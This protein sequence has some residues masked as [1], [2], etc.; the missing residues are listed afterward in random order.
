[1]NKSRIDN[2]IQD[3]QTLTLMKSLLI[4]LMLVTSVYAEQPQKVSDTQFSNSVAIDYNGEEL[5]LSL[6]GLT[7][8]KKLIFKVYLM[9][10]YIEKT[11]DNNF[12]ISD[13]DI[14][15]TVLQHEGAKQISMVF[16]R[17]LSA[18]QIKESLTSGIKKNSGEGEYQLIMPSVEIFNRAITKD[19]K[20]ND[21][22]T[23]R[24]LP[25][26]TLVSL[27]QGQEISAIKDERFAKI[28]WS[29]WFSDKSVVKRERL[30]E[31]LLTSS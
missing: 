31:K 2:L 22:F 14:Y 6:T 24:W 23:L 7:I 11:N 18:T 19:V 12:N 4:G 20:E 1:M 27:F 13:K 30:I 15:S 17:S 21:E 25:D 3:F 8:R 10:H 9:A 29:I 16:M 5:E 26:G 28:L